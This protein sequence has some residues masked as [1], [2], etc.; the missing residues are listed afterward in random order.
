MRTNGR[1]LCIPTKTK[2]F[3]RIVC[4][5]GEIPMKTEKGLECV[6]LR[7]KDNVICQE[8]QVAIETKDGKICIHPNSEPEK[9][10]A[11]ENR[12]RNGQV[13]ILFTSVRSKVKVNRYTSPAIFF[14]LRHFEDLHCKRNPIPKGLLC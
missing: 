3:Q 14:N 9:I 2:A 10:P 5:K 12:C 11:L 4:P 8:G 7:H 1:E 6:N 13:R